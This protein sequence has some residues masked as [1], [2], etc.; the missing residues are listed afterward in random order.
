MMWTEEEE[1]ILKR[2]AEKNFKP[3][4]ISKVLK[5]RSPAAIEKRAIALGIPLRTHPDIDYDAFKQMIKK[6]ATPCQV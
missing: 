6:G 3:S 2:M 1:S 4:D 5:S